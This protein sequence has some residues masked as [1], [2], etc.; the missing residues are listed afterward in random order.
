MTPYAVEFRGVVTTGCRYRADTD[1][2]LGSV[3]VGEADVVRSIDEADLKANVRVLIDGVKVAEG[4]VLSEL[5]WGYSD[6][7]PMD[8][9]SCRVGG[10]DLVD[11][12]AKREGADVALRIEELP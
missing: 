12:L 2:K 10:F 8:P 4:D 7:T 1:Q 6:Y 5:G 11:E 9:D 3:F